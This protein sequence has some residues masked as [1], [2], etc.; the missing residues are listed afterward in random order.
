MQRFG[1][2]EEIGEVCLFLASEKAKYITGETLGVQGG[3]G[4]RP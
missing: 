2:A 1:T 3:V 4:L